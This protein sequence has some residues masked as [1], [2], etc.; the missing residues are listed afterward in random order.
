MGVD[1]SMKVPRTLFIHCLWIVLF[2]ASC[3]SVHAAEETLFY[4]TNNA[5][6]PFFL[7]TS[8]RTGT[9]A[10]NAIDDAAGAIP[11]EGNISNGIVASGATITGEIRL[12]ASDSD[13]TETA[14]FTL[15]LKKNG[16]S[17]G[18]D[19]IAVPEGGSLV[20]A[21]YPLSFSIT[22][23]FTSAD[24]LIWEVATSYTVSGTEDRG[25]QLDPDHSFLVFQ[26]TFPW[27]M[28]LPA[29]IGQTVAAQ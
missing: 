29:M 10:L 20:Y 19:T 4:D 5:F 23:S 12:A 21:T 2:S 22:D 14:D 27:T 16:V 25:M 18:S 17:I 28:F 11:F 13:V 8:A 24:D 26:K 9:I 7:S 3:V 6:G 1:N 15:T